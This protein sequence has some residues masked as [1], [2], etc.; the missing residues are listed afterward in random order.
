MD[1]TLCPVDYAASGMIVDDDVHAVLVK[2]RLFLI[3]YPETRC[4]FFISSSPFYF[5][6]DCPR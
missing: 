5:Y 3:D 6:R 2:V 4:I 1:E